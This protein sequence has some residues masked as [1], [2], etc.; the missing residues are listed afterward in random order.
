MA[1]ASTRIDLDTQGNN[2]V[3][4]LT[5]HARLAVAESG[6]TEGLLCVYAPHTTVGIT[7]LEFEPGANEDLGALLDRLVPADHDWQHNR[8]DSNGHAHA[9]A[10]L[11]GPSVTVP[12]LDGKPALGT[13]QTIAL[14]DFDDRPRTRTVL[15]QVLS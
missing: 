8:Y 3:V 14:V 7:A 12:V 15:F 2:E 9:R 11:M 6:V 5:E 10:A 13:W 4:D 1:T